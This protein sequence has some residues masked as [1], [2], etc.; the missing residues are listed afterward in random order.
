VDAPSRVA[1]VDATLATD[2]AARLADSF[3]SVWPTPTLSF[4][5]PLLSPL[6]SPFLWLSTT[7]T[8]LNS[9]GLA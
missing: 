9:S 2:P 6:Q 1:T 5:V 7:M 8:L 4:S 3:P